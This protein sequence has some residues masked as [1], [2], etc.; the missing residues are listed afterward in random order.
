M[1]PFVPLLIWAIIADP[2]WLPSQVAAVI[3]AVGCVLAA[4]IVG[5]WLAGAEQR[6]YVRELR[7]GT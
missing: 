6:T 2:S 7:D 1:I 5:V 4:V 3:L